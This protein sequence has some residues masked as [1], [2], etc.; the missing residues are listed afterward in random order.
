[1]Y[2]PK[3]SSWIPCLALTLALF[4][5][6][7][8]ADEPAAPE[9]P[10]AQAA[11]PQAT[12]ES[13]TAAP[14]ATPSAPSADSAPSAA[15]AAN[16]GETDDPPLGEID[17]Q[18][19][20]YLSGAQIYDR[21]LDNRFDAYEQE[22]LMESGDRGGNIE[23]VEME[24][25]YMNTERE[26]KG[27]LSKSIAKYEAPQDV[28]HMG[29]LVVNKAEGV[30]DQFVY[31]PSSRRVRRV[32][33]RGESIVGTDFALEDIIPPEF[34]DATYLRLPDET[35][36]TID[37]F[38]VELTPT[39]EADS[40]YTKVIAYVEKEHYVPLRNVYWDNQ[41]VKIKE[42]WAEPSSITRHEA[43]DK[44]GLKEVW[45]AQKSKITNLKLDSFT[46]LDVVKL[47]ANP[48]LR[49]RDFSQRTL[50]AGH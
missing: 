43:F 9:T 12:P 1:M 8:A 29:Y 14:A 6:G 23:R 49:K 21:V 11:A 46:T 36:S 22:I 15:S 2:R 35:V 28:R 5:L 18:E 40:N 17:G 34:E 33:L 50:T 3:R 38:V 42:L 26:K 41:G 27:I 44:S 45:V 7:L 4:P 47:D 30:D 20:D 37:C 31:L 32:N 16:R 48:K 39:E 13:D 25:K 24:V 10:S 19:A